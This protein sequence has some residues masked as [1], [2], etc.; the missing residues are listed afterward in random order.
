MVR[1]RQATTRAGSIVET[2]LEGQ[3]RQPPAARGKTWLSRPS[4]GKGFEAFRATNA[5]DALGR[6]L[7]HTPGCAPQLRPGMTTA[8]K[9]V[10]ELGRGAADCLEHLR[11]P[12]PIMDVGAMN[13]PPKQE[14]RRVG[15]DVALSFLDLL[16]GIEAGTPL[17]SA[18]LT[19]RKAI[20]PA[21]GLA[22]PPFQIAISL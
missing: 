18:V 11:H 12:I 16:A 17:L 22:L 8:C 5:P 10:K 19:D 2:G 6:P 9:D 1:Q 14:T 3:L 4:P 15:D 7:A 21:L 13:D 20:T